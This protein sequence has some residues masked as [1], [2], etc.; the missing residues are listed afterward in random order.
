M[1]SG[2]AKWLLLPALAMSVCFAQA[3]Q[4]P[5]DPQS[6]PKVDAQQLPPTGSGESSS[7]PQ[8]PLPPDAQ[9]PDTPN[10]STQPKHQS[11]VKRKLRQL[12]PECA[13]IFFRG[14][15]W[16]SHPAPPPSNSPESEQAAKKAMEVGAFYYAQKNYRAAESRFREAVEFTPDN[17]PAHFKLAQALE[18]LGKIEEARAN[19]EICLKADPNGEFAAA[20]RKALSQVQANSVEHPK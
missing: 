13:T 20:A 8:L 16:A 18:K 14:V 1:A 7:K 9:V 3:T 10:T 11:T 17:A 19:Y 4:H 5:G 2:S 15:C 12:A 6:A